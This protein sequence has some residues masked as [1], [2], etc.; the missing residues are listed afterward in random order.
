MDSIYQK[1]IKKLSS[2]TDNFVETIKSFYLNNY[3]FCKHLEVIK[4]EIVSRNISF[5][6]NREEE[7]EEGELA[8][9]D[10]QIGFEEDPDDE[11]EE[12]LL[13]SDETL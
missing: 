7:I 10:A 13:E 1:G 9:G 8:E 12:L 5:D 3:S 2:L 6:E 11:D 4:K